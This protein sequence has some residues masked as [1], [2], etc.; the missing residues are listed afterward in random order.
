MVFIN[1]NIIVMVGG[2]GY[3]IMSV[4]IVIK[5]EVKMN[6]KIKEAIKDF[7]KYT[8]GTGKTMHDLAVAVLAVS[9]I[10]EIKKIKNIS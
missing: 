3:K 10:E 6:E 5:S 2:K 4:N 1:G 8:S 7:S 9:K